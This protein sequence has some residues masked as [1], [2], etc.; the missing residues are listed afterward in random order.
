VA[1]ELRRPRGP[2]ARVGHRGAA[3]LAPEN[4]LRSL[5][6][7]VELGCDM[8]E[9]DVLGLSD[10]TLV[11][12]HSNNLREVSHGAARGRVRGRT[13]NGLRRVAPDLPTF[14]D[15]LAFLAYRFPETVLQ[16]DLKQRGVEE[17]VVAALRRHGVAERSWISGFDAVSLQ[18]VASLAPELPRS[19]T[20]PRDRLGISRRGP[21]APLVR[22]T[23]A[24]IGAGLPRRLPS[25]LERA[26]AVAATLHYSVA[27]TEAIRAAHDAGAAVYVWTVDDAE[28]AR[29]LVSAGADGIITNDPRIFS[30][31]NL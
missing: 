12:A 29:R 26:N 6:L 30:R 8:L 3:A 1:V 10:G 9:F 7:A 19:Y 31:L 15:A 28:L 21:L 5:E 2:V 16:I 17:G 14:D 11:L 22:G 23:L 27:S 24:S 25:L 18:R 13:L 20:L 4:T